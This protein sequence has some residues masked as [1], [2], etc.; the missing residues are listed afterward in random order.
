MTEAE[1]LQGG[2][3]IC[4]NSRVIRLLIVAGAR[5]VAPCCLLQSVSQQQYC[6]KCCIASLLPVPNGGS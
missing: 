2:H 6:S 5:L 3:L 1:Q 4:L